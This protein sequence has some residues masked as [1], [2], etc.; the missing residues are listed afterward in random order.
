M[1]VSFNC[2]NL[3]IQNLDI[4]KPRGLERPGRMSEIVSELHSLKWE[5]PCSLGF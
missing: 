3:D 5:D 1:T 4:L 2:P